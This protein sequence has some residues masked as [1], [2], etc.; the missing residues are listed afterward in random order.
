MTMKEPTRRISIRAIRRDPPDY[1][2]LGRALILLAAAEAEAKAQAD[3]ERAK[4]DE[5]CPPNT[6]TDPEDS[7]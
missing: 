7:K 1:V 3:A 4:S 5:E 6:D 2:K